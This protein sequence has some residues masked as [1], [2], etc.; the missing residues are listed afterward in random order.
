MEDLPQDAPQM[1]VASCVYAAQGIS[2]KRIFFEEPKK[3]QLKVDPLPY[4][5]VPFIING[6]VKLDCQH[7]KCRRKQ[8]KGSDKVPDV[9]A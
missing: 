5:G 7:G 6:C 1:C 3:G 2:H 9:S 8:P 4:D